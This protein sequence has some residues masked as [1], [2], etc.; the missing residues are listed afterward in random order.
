MSGPSGRS[1]DERLRRGGDDRLRRGGEDWAAGLQWVLS[2]HLQRLAGR[3][4][5]GGAGGSADRTVRVGDAD[6]DRVAEL[7]HTAG[8]EGRLSGVEV[9]DRLE[10]AF[11]ARTADELL[12]LLADLPV[13]GDPLPGTAPVEQ[14][15]TAFFREERRTGEWEVP[16]RLTV[17][18]TMGSAVLDLT[19]ATVRSPEVVLDLAVTG[20]SVAITVPAGV[21]VDV[22][23][24]LTVFGSWDNRAPA[25]DRHPLAG[26]D[27]IRVTGTVV[28]GRVTVTTG[29]TGRWRRRR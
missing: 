23:E 16:P 15:I 25:E 14:E 8:A 18:V 4:G 27:V 11:A 5:P 26:A 12:P 2:S 13:D 6:R 28:G 1:D 29:R 9:A 19:Q 3:G 20:G 21:P 7:L 10:R 17:T 24:G 22:A